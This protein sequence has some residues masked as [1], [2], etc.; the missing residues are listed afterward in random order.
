[1]CIP[2]IPPPLFLLL[3]LLQLSFG[4][5]WIRESE[6]FAHT[7]LSFAFVNLKPVV[8]GR[9]VRGLLLATCNP[10]TTSGVYDSYYFTGILLVYAHAWH[11]QACVPCAGSYLLPCCT[12]LLQRMHANENME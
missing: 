5:F 11:I 7:A 6:V 12:L 9:Y 10:G 2:S 8:P 1:L 4:P 3:V